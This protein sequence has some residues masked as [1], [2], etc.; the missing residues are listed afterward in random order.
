MQ[1]KN[2]I[3]VTFIS[4][5]KTFINPSWRISICFLLSGFLLIL[6]ITATYGA[7][8][9]GDAV[10]YLSTADSLRR[11]WRFTDYTGAAYIYWPPLYP[12]IL[13]TFSWLTRLDTF[14]VAWLLNA[15]AF[16]LLVM[17]SGRIFRH[18]F[19]EEPLWFYWGSLATLTSLPL[20]RLSANITSDP[21]FIVLVLA[22]L[23]LASRYLSTPKKATL[24]GLGSIG[25]VASL[26]RWHGV[27]LV[28]SLVLLV[29]IA[30]RHTPKRAIWLAFWAGLFTSL[31]FTLWVAGRNYRLT[32]SFLGNR[33]TS[34][35]DFYH[36]LSD[37]LM[38]M[39]HWLLPDQLI[40]R[41]SPLVLGIGIMIVLVIINRRD[42]WRNLLCQLK[43]NDFIPWLIFA[44]LY[45]VFVVST[46]I[47]YD[48]PTYFDDRYYAALFVFII[49][50]LVLIIHNLIMPHLER[51]FTPAKHPE[52]IS[53]I[54]ILLISC[55][56][57][58]YPG[59]RLYKY[60]IVSR[61][62]GEPTYNIYNTRQFHESEVVQFLNDYEFEEADT[63]YSNYNAAVYFFTHKMTLQAPISASGEGDDLDL[64]ALVENYADWPTDGEAYLIWFLP[65]YWHYYYQPANLNAVA[66][67]TL[68]FASADG[69]IYHVRGK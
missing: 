65:N 10:D 36:N 56:W 12:I 28:F 26:Q 6:F 2:F 8:V 53:R 60:A 40:S 54:V 1:K 3:K 17:L 4:T 42:N 48:H 43:S 27:L 44:P 64:D 22:F 21:I 31:P 67:L 58:V 14:I 29:L 61:Q 59:Y 30:H 63:L 68:L 13:A 41:V 11:E 24:I 45:F 7:G 50:L 16:G 19:D 33:D 49:L 66:D 38:K 35:I 37:A 62:R 34:G 69:Y 57:L 23:L 51:W 32:G 39:N 47:A 46:S 52:V 5:I 25:A 20:I 9:S 18:I 15:F 55:I